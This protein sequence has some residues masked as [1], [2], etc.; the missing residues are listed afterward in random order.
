MGGEL[1]QAS[2]P[3]DFPGLALHVA[4]DGCRLLSF[5]LLGRLFVVLSAAQFR[6]DACLLAGAFETPQGGIKM[7][8]FFDA[9]AGH[10]N[11]TQ[12]HKSRQRPAAKTI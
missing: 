12:I 6:Q 1:V 9:N 11:L 10:Y 8:A 7:L 4:L 2:P 5:A 3:G